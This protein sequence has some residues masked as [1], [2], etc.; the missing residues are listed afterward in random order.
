[1]ICLTVLWLE[2]ASFEFVPLQKYVFEFHSQMRRYINVSLDE[3]R[4]KKLKQ[5]GENKHMLKK[6]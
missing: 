5:V 6:T 2:K 3:F 1:M 4:K